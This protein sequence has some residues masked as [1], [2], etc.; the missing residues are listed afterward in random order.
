M[1]V[2]ASS[3]LRDQIIAQINDNSN[4]LSMPQ[5]LYQILHEVDK[6]DFSPQKLAEIIKTD[7]ALTARILSLANSTFY[8][9]FSRTTTVSQAVSVLGVSTVKCLALSTTVLKPELIEKN[10][11]LNPK[12]FFTY[13]L[14]N[15]ATA[16]CLSREL[17]LK[18]SEEMFIIGLLNDIGLIFLVHHYPSEYRQVLSLKGKADSLSSAE[19][20]ILGIDHYEISHLLARKWRLPEEMANSIG[21]QT[22]ENPSERVKKMQ[23]TINLASLMNPNNFSGFESTLED[24]LSEVNQAADNLSVSRDQLDSVSG[25]LMSST[26]EAAENLGVDIGSIEDLLAKANQEIWKAYST[27][28]QL[29]KIRQDLNDKLFKEERYR[30]VLELKNSAMATL[31]HYINNAIMAVYGRSQIMRQHHQSGQSEIVLK[32]LDKD[33][34]IIDKSIQK[35]VAVLEEVKEI[36]QF[37]QDKLTGSTEAMNLDERIDERISKMDKEQKWFVWANKEQVTSD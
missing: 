8:Q 7:P 28:D 22:I 20:E 5:S 16:E 19:I 33:L 25:K 10:S 29:F 34:N 32:D 9:R 27:I 1:P 26:I 30:G 6:K 2:S 17:K 14:L 21:C 4:L 3:K 23:A 13:V 31:F 15:A 37:E 11:G 36:A 35:I 24:R 18:A 12:E